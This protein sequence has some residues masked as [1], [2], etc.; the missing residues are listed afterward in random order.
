M[1][2]YF[3]PDDNFNM[4]EQIVKIMK[5]MYNL[6]ETDRFYIFDNFTE[7]YVDTIS[8]PRKGVFSRKPAL[9]KLES[10]IFTFDDTMLDIRDSYTLSR[11]FENILFSVVRDDNYINKQ[12]I[13]SNNT[14]YK[15]IP[16][17]QMDPNEFRKHI[18]VEYKDIPDSTITKDMKEVFRSVC[19]LY[20]IFPGRSFYIYNV[21]EKLFCTKKIIENNQIQS[22]PIEFTYENEIITH[23]YI[24]NNALDLYIQNVFNSIY[25][26][27]IIKQI[28]PLKF[29]LVRKNDMYSEIKEDVSKGIKQKENDNDKIKKILEK[30][31]IKQKDGIWDHFFLKACAVGDKYANH[32]FNLIAQRNGNTLTFIEFAYDN[33]DGLI[34]T[35]VDLLYLDVS[36]LKQMELQILSG[37]LVP[38]DIDTYMKEHMN[39]YNLDV[40]KNTSGISTTSF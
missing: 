6:K 35:N 4:E 5:R 40:A 8:S 23:D 14:Q 32:P 9:F 7:K 34:A 37:E 28:G 1:Q 33:D 39:D 11:I 25:E 22:V 18:C 26:D 24:E 10:N 2:F 30:N 27:L 31:N 38:L 13:V 21:E 20:R 36:A 15:I 17:T 3:R 29:K 12:W 19:Q 16:F